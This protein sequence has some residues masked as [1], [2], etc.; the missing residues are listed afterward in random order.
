MIRICTIVVVVTGICIREQ[1]AA[2]EVD[3]DV[4]VFVVDFVLI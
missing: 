2:E 1:A 3:V 4:V